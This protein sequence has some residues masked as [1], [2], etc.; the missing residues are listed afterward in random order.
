MKKLF[1]GSIFVVF[2]CLFLAVNQTWGNEGNVQLE[3]TINTD[4]RCFAMSTKIQNSRYNILVDCRNL[5]Y[6]IGDDKSVY[7]LWAQPSNQSQRPARLGALEYGKKIFSTSVP[8]SSLFV[9]LEKDSSTRNPSGDKIMEGEI[10]PI[11]F[12]EEAPSEFEEEFN[13]EIITPTPT[14]KSGGLVSGAVRVFVTLVAIILG[15]IIFGIIAFAIYR[16]RKANS[17]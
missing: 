1:L 10:I 17:L 16:Y 4:Q 6:P 5:V 12:L 3:N 11:D 2:L 13:E 15:I 7:M 8:F 9:T 14:P